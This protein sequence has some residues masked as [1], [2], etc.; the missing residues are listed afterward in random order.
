VKFFRRKKTESL[1]ESQ[2]VP[3]GTFRCDVC[4]VVEPLVCLCG[5]VADVL[6]NPPKVYTLCGVCAVWLGFGEFRFPQ[7]LRFNL[8]VGEREK[9]R[10]LHKELDIVKKEMDGV[11]LNVNPSAEYLEE[12]HEFLERVP[13]LRELVRLRFSL[14]PQNII[15]LSGRLTNGEFVDPSEIEKAN[16]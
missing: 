13:N 4:K 14:L 12:I 11:T 10:A 7:G 15:D 9:I 8:S 16:N 1:S 5:A 6:D 2:G 3:R